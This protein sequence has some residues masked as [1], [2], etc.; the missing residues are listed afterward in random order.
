MELAAALLGGLELVV[1]GGIVV[2]GVVVGVV[3]AGTPDVVGAEELKVLGE[4]VAVVIGSVVEPAGE[5]GTREGE[6]ERES[7]TCC[8]HLAPPREPATAAPP[9]MKPKA[10]WTNKQKAYS[11]TFAPFLIF[12]PRGCEAQAKKKKKRFHSLD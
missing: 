12:E 1:G 6:R 10:L 3:S 4:L 11:P 2:G 9:A 7:H 8:F 5:V